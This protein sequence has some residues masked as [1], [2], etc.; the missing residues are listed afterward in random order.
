MTV[1]SPETSSA[2]KRPPGIVVGQRIEEELYCVRLNDP[3]AVE[4]EIGIPWDGQILR[5]RIW[6]SAI[7]VSRMPFW[8]CRNGT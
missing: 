4:T 1:V 5:Y 8:S 6:N 3:T 2:L 7:P